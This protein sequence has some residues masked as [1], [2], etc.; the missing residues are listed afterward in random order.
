MLLQLPVPHG[1]LARQADHL[2][3]QRGLLLAGGGQLRLPAGQLLL[4][5]PQLLRG[6]QGDTRLRRTLLGSLL[7]STHR[8]KAPLQPAHLLLHPDAGGEGKLE[9]KT[10]HLSTNRQV[11]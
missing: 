4:R 6:S 5:S 10:R 3:R 1:H 2:S 7:L 9:P 8:R 11:P